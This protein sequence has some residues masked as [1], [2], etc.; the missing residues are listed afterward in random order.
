MDNLMTKKKLFKDKIATKELYKM[1]NFLENTICYKRQP[2]M[3]LLT[4][5]K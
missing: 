4:M 1:G 2:I 3:D 5:R